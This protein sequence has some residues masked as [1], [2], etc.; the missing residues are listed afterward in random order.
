MYTKHF[1]KVLIGFTLMLALGFVGL[2]LVRHYT[3]ETDT[4]I[5]S[6]PV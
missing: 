5:F 3:G 6:Q 1:F 4:P 2:I